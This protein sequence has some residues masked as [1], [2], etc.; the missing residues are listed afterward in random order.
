MLKKI[1]FALRD[2]NQ[3]ELTRDSSGLRNAREGLTAPWGGM[4][5]SYK[6]WLRF[7]PSKGEAGETIGKT[8][9]LQ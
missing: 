4:N 2:F 7:S 3:I 6:G 9:L 8:R 5:I 1:I